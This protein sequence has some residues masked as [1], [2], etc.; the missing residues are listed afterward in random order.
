MTIRFRAADV[1][2]ELTGAH[3]LLGLGSGGSEP[4]QHIIMMRALGDAPGVADVLTADTYF[5]YRGQAHA[6]YGCVT[7]AVLTPS[8]LT[9]GCDTRRCPQLPDGDFEVEL[10]SSAGRHDAI[11][12]VLRALIDGPRLVIKDA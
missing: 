4:D 8:S 12:A 6:G 3:V 9:L 5:E 1:H 2:I 10:D 11:A 7:R